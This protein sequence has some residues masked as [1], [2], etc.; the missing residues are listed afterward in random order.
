MKTFFLLIAA[1]SV[2]VALRSV[3]VSIYLSLLNTHFTDRDGVMLGGLGSDL[4]QVFGMSRSFS[5]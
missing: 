2:S 4:K 5:E 3:I 1:G